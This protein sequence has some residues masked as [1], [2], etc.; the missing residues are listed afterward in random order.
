MREPRKYSFGEG[1]FPSTIGLTAYFISRY[2]QITNEGK[3]VMHLT[4]TPFTNKP[5]EIFS[6]LSLTNRNRLEAS[7]F[8][9]MEDFLMFLW[10]FLMN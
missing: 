4:A 1:E 5:A 10:I 6:M 2:L 3:N 8:N 9:Y 7:G